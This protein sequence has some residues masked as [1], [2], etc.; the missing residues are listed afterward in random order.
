MLPRLH[1]IMNYE[2]CPDLGEGRPSTWGRPRP[3]SISLVTKWGNSLFEVMYII[4]RAATSMGKTAMDDNGEGC[5][6]PGEGRHGSGVAF[7]LPSAT[8][9][10]SGPFLAR[11]SI[12]K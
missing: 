7:F 8:M 12:K 3:H 5:H 2:G 9:P 10:R 6:S 11:N 4:M 1:D